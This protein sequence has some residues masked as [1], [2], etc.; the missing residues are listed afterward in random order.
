MSD[1]SFKKQRDIILRVLFFLNAAF[2]L[3]T[4]VLTFFRLGGGNAFTWVMA[5]LM[6]INGLIFLYFGFT[7]QKSRNLKV[8]I[9]LCFLFINIFFTLTDQ[10]G[11]FDMITMIINMVLFLMLIMQWFKPRQKQSIE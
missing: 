11:F 2:W 3:V 7:I 10:F 4:S 1:Q 8:I 9:A 5:L 6:V